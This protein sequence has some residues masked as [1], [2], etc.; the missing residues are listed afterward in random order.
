M[1]S[2]EGTTVMQIIMYNLNTEDLLVFFAQNL[3]HFA[4]L[5]STFNQP[6]EKQWFL[7]SSIYRSFK[8]RG[9]E[10]PIKSKDLIIFISQWCSISSLQ[11][12]QSVPQG[13]L[14][15]PKF[16]SR[17]R[18]DSIHCYSLAAKF[19]DSWGALEWITCPCAQDCTGTWGTSQ[20]DPACQ[21]V[22]TD[23]FHTDPA[24]SQI[25]F[26]NSSP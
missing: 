24:Q 17:G 7:P 2:Q 19:P 22:P 1:N 18:A 21:T 16:G 5:L 15:V 3:E 26:Y 8:W 13:S 11:S 9:S 23:Q 10:K 6:F 4:R 12:C 20:A 14:Q 25:H